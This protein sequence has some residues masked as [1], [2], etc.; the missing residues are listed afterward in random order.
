MRFLDLAKLLIVNV[1]YVL[2]ELHRMYYM[3]SIASDC[4]KWGKGV[5]LFLPYL[6]AS[7]IIARL[8]CKL[9]LKGMH[10]TYKLLFNHIVGVE[11]DTGRRASSAVRKRLRI[12]VIVRY[13]CAGPS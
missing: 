4:V 11:L 1:R 10:P 3:L 6:E 13:H 12:L 5:V 2:T 8:R 9:V 7:V